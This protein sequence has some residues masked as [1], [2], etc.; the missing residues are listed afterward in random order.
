MKR[1]LECQDQMLQRSPAGNVFKVM[2]TTLNKV[3]TT[4]DNFKI[5]FLAHLTGKPLIEHLPLEIDA[6]F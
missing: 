6:S 5:H 4:L 1:R 2:N 3:Q